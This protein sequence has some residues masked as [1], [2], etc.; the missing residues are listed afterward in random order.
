MAR[1][2]A[3]AAVPNTVS[4]RRTRCVAIR[5]VTETTTTTTTGTTGGAGCGSETN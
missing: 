5:L 1:P 2:I 3:H 4:D